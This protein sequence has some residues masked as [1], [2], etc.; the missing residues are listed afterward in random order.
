VVRHSGGG[1][2]RPAEVRARSHSNTDPPRSAIDPNR[3]HRMN[4]EPANLYALCPQLIVS[5]D[6]ETRHVRK[7]NRNTEKRA[8][9]IDLA[10]A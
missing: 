3:S 4:S 2:A 10:A 9:S 1:E 8:A 5:G 7:P 6:I